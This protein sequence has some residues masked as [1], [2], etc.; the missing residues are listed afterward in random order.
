[1]GHKTKKISRKQVNDFFKNK[2]IAIAGVSRNP[3][4]FGHRT[5]KELSEKGYT[6]LPINPEADAIDNVKCYKRVEDLPGD[7]ESLLILTPKEKTD[8][9][10]RSAIKKGIK[11]IWVQQM[12]NTDETLKIAEE[13]QKEIITGKCIY[14]FT[15]PVA[16]VHRFHRTLVKIFGGLPK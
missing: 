3:K 11:N 10:L 9:I 12:S 15:E 16:G 7:I 8:E 1:M 4:K 13:Y 6:I 5:F 2:K 14:M